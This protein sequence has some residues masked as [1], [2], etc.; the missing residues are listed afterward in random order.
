MIKDEDRE[1]IQDLQRI[2]NMTARPTVPAME[3]ILYHIIP[4]LGHRIHTSDGLH[5]R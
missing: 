4:V 1:A 3:A 2:K 5:G